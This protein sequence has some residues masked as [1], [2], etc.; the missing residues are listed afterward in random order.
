MS[1]AD[2]VEK[3]FAIGS[4]LRVKLESRVKPWLKG[5]GASVASVLDSAHVE[6]ARVDRP[7]DVLLVKSLLAKGK[8]TA[9]ERKQKA[10]L[11][12]LVAKSFWI[13]ENSEAIKD[14]L[15]RDVIGD[16]PPTRAR[17]LET[18]WRGLS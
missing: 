5:K 14:E 3:E 12:R 1:K 4:S 8:K 2:I 17:A 6:T 16:P 9:D 13:V 15:M 18:Y 11:Q 10:D 7:I